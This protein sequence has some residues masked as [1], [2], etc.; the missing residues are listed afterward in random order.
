M[1]A[2][3]KLVENR[4]AVSTNIT[5]LERGYEVDMKSIITDTPVK[6]VLVLSATLLWAAVSITAPAA[7][8]TEEL[9]DRAVQ[10]ERAG[11]AAK[12]I[13]FYTR[14]AELD[15]QNAA[16][17]NNRGIAY[18]RNKEYDRAIE[19]FDRALSIAP[20]SVGTLNNRGMA[21]QEK[22][23]VK[24]AL[25]DYTDAL[26]IDGENSQALYNR[27]LLYHRIGDGQRA[28]E[29]I[30]KVVQFEPRNIRAL[31]LTGKLHLA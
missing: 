25:Q 9:F 24:R 5:T 23:D 20:D 28:L 7:D 8:P 4:P 18:S 17:F 1:S 16:I 13:E 15:P 26:H 2:L 29:D 30:N 3:S 21:Y 6:M 22:G 12:A 14:C 31:I 19:D 27:A 11:D 10:A